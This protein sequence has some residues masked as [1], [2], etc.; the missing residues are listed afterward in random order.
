MCMLLTESCLI[1]GD[2]M[3]CNLPGSSVHGI[4]HARVLHAKWRWLYFS[5]PGDLPN[6]G[7]K[8]APPALQMDSLSSNLVIWEAPVCGQPAQLLYPLYEQDPILQ[9][10]SFILSDIYSSFHRFPA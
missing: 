5:P 3:N 6:P 1:L 2:L 8:P 7:I 10:M 4:F 9:N